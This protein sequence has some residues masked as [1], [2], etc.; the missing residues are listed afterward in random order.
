VPAWPRTRD[1]LIEEQ[2]RLAALEPEPWQMDPR[3]R[4]GGVFVCFPRGPSGPGRAG[5]R[6][7]AGASVDD[8]TVVVSG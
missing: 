1:E 4:I 6:A 2:L 8:E 3:A 5:D 7:W